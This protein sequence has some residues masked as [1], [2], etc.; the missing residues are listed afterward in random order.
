M[1][2]GFSATFSADGAAWPQEWT[3]GIEAEHF[4]VAEKKRLT[5][6]RPSGVTSE[7]CAR[8]SSNGLAW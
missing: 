5:K 1:S 2:A 3:I 8:R 7:G 4:T 6:L